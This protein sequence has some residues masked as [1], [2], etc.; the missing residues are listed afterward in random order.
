MLL[1]QTLSYLP[2]QVLGPLSQFAALLLWTH[3]ADGRTVG[4]VTLITATQELL[5]AT[6]L[7]FWSHYVLRDMGGLVQA[8]DGA[9]LRNTATYV[10]AASGV[11][12]SMTA[13]LV[14]SRFIV[15]DAGRVCERPSSSSPSAAPSIFISPSAQ[16]SGRTS[17]SI[18]SKT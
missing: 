7:S 11:L 14:L 9:A 16:G 15:P 3:F 6:L 13:L 2:G 5:S 1:K 17:G 4:A 12:Q 18:R 10:L 8:G